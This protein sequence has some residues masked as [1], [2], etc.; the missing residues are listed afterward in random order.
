MLP[1][2]L[3]VPALVQT[4]PPDPGELPGPWERMLE[5][6]RAEQHPWP[7][8]R[9]LARAAVNADAMRSEPL[10]RLL[11]SGE[12]DLN[13][14]PATDL[15]AFWVKNDWGQEVD[16]ALISPDGRVAAT[17][18][19]P[20][21][22]SALEESILKSGWKSRGER[23][24]DFV[25]NDAGS[26]DAWGDAFLDAGH[27]MIFID[28]LLRADAAKPLPWWV[29]E[30]PPPDPMLLVLK[31]KAEKEWIKALEGLRGHKGYERWPGL[32]GAL[33]LAPGTPIQ[34][35]KDA[36]RP[37]L[38]E[39]IQELHRTPQSEALWAAWSQ[40]A[41]RLPMEVSEFTPSLFSV[42]EGD[43]WPPPAGLRAVLPVLK[44]R[45]DLRI[46]LAYCHNQ[47][48]AP[49]PA[50][51]TSD[52]EF[53]RE[54]MQRIQDWGL[55]GLEALVRLKAETDGLVWIED[56][57]HMWG[58]DWETSNLH[59]YLRRIDKDWLPGSW[60][61]ALRADPLEDPPL[62]K[63]SAPS[64][65]P[66]LA[67]DAQSDRVLQKGWKT[68]RGS[69]ALDAWGPGELH[70]DPISKDLL[71]R[72]REDF[73][74]DAKPRWFLFHGRALNAS[75]T[76]APDPAFIQERLRSFGLPRLEVLAL[77]LSKHP[78]QKEAHIERFQLLR[79][80]LPQQRLEGDFRLDAEAALL[81]VTPD[82][83]WSPSAEPWPT[84]AQRVLPKLEEKLRHWPSDLG[85]WKAWIAWSEIAARKPKAVTLAASLEP[86]PGL[87]FE[88]AQ[89]IA[90]QL[91]NRGDWK[92]LQRF[93]QDHWDI[94]VEQARP[95]HPAIQPLDPRLADELGV[96]LAF[97][98]DALQAQGQAAAAKPLR[99]KYKE[100]T[101]R[102]PPGP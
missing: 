65:T 31:E 60:D 66:S 41:R 18:A 45:G 90:S 47:L 73:G 9:V 59:A 96:W 33:S 4:V 94:L 11:S 17:G 88:A 35:Q 48:H 78:E 50:A 74:L 69:P 62:P 98:E 42:P 3:A 13:P 83:T 84:A 10:M 85:A 79:N 44:A 51:I 40:V 102:K 52:S 28:G 67:L 29:W 26:G 81:P 23:F 38:D 21:T 22:G 64:S 2:L 56:L 61:I 34:S 14:F 43:P 39:L 63:T 8:W 95:I 1:L 24:I 49:L 6:H 57:R 92:A 5:N 82:G 75:G 30:A 77:F 86:W 46:L 19:G 58:K 32:P 16:W 93:S 25:K 53:R 37:M 99:A 100:L 76:S 68:L 80:R 20:P 55:P 89:L 36:L 101:L 12:L 15:T 87:R 91:R 70:W 71:K 54:R 72:V 7:K 27:L 97:L